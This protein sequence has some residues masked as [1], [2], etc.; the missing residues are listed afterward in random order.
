MSLFFLNSKSKLAGT[1]RRLSITFWFVVF[2]IAFFAL[3]IGL[4]VL[5]Y[6][7]SLWEVAASYAS[8][9]P[10]EI[11]AIIWFVLILVVVCWDVG[12]ICIV[13][14]KD[15]VMKRRQKQAEAISDAASQVPAK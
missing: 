4:V 1:F 6:I 11:V 15:L 5:N 7:D 13:W 9:L 8:I 10:G 2:G 3:W 14:G 12:K